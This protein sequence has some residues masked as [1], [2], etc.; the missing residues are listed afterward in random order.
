MVGRDVPRR[1]RLPAHQQLVVVRAFILL[2]ASL[3]MFLVVPLVLS[4]SAWVL[5]LT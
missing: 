3:F 1:L 4:S 5:A 2:S